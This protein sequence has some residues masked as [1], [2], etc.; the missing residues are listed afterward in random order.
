MFWKKKNSP[1]RFGKQ[2][3][4]YPEGTQWLRQQTNKSHL[5]FRLILYVHFE[6]NMQTNVKSY[7]EFN[8]ANVLIITLKNQ[9]S[10]LANWIVERESNWRFHLSGKYWLWFFSRFLLQQWE[11]LLWCHQRNQKTEFA[12]ASPNWKRNRQINWESSRRI[13]THQNGENPETQRSLRSPTE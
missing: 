9:D 1:S 10:E 3:E 6:K 8:W 4:R 11:V 7:G 13:T 2:V 5:L 12:F